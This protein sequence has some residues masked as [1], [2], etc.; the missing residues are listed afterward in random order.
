MKKKEK[1]KKKW[2]IILIIILLIIGGFCVFIEIYGGGIISLIQPVN[3]STE[4]QEQYDIYSS[5]LEK[6]LNSDGDDTSYF[7]VYHI[8][9]TEI[10]VIA[11]ESLNDEKVILFYIKDHRL[12]AREYDQIAQINVLYNVQ[13]DAYDYYL[14]VVDN[15]GNYIFYLLSDIINESSNPYTVKLGNKDI[16]IV[17]NRDGSK[18]NYAKKD[19]LFIDNIDSTLADDNYHTVIMT[20]VSVGKFR[21]YLKRGISDANKMNLNYLITDNTKRKVKEKLLEYNILPG[22]NIISDS[23]TK[24]TTTTTKGNG[25][26]TTTKKATTKCNSGFVYV[27][28]DNRCYNNKD[29]KNVITKCP[30]GFDDLGVDCAKPVD[31]SLCDSGNDQYEKISGRCYDRYT[32]SSKGMFC[33]S[34]YEILW[35]SYSGKDFNGDCYRYMKPNF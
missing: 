24:K 14:C 1:C 21:Y 32:Y 35:G 19:V 12:V 27:S 15:N 23:T 10:P 26:T 18:T 16:Y 13:R 28:D 34:G 29:V 3:L 22:Q 33:P 9:G 7:K 31:S 11:L 4:A 25:T 6:Y 2:L 30:S 20:N 8:E 5:E 17:T